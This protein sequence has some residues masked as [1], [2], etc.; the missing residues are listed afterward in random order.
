MTV[1]IVAMVEVVGVVVV[2]NYT[3]ERAY[4][5]FLSMFKVYFY[6]FKHYRNK[7]I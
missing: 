2:V 7:S 1:L 3:S 5:L 4:Y 6:L